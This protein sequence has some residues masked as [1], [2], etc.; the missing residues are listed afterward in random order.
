MLHNSLKAATI[1]SWDFYNKRITWQTL[2]QSIFSSQSF[3]D[4]NTCLVLHLTS[5]GAF[6]SKFLGVSKSQCRIG[7]GPAGED[8]QEEFPFQS[9]QMGQD[10]E[11]HRPARK[12]GEWVK[13]WGKYYS[14]V[15]VEHHPWHQK[16]APKQRHKEVV[17]DPGKRHSLFI[18]SAG[19]WHKTPP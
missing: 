6:L 1:S 11:T 7:L 18:L 16:G 12:E 9:A 15:G 13:D 17:S 3:S 19:S 10:M 14:P 2:S 8:I 4:F 5:A